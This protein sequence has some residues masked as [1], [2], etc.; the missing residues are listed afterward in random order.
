M[1]QE[2]RVCEKMTEECESHC[3]NG[4]EYKHFYCSA[5]HAS[6]GAKYNS[7][8]LEKL[9]KK[10][11]ELDYKDKVYDSFILGIAL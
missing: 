7:Y 9:R 4:R 5:S 1:K 11:K 8:S 6:F 10:F 2:C 3:S